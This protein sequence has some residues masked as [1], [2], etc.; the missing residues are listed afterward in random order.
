[1]IFSSQSTHSFIKCSLSLN[2][3]KILIKNSYHL[4]Y[5]IAEFP[6]RKW[7]Q[8]LKMWEVP[9]NVANIRF[10][11]NN[12][13]TLKYVQI[14][15]RLLQKIK[16]FK[17]IAVPE[18]LKPFPENFPFKTEPWNVQKQALNFAYNFDACLHDVDMGLGKSKISIDLMNQF[19]REGLINGVIVFAPLSCLYN[20]KDE[21]ETHS[22]SNC[23]LVHKKIMKPEKI[24]DSELSFFV[25]GVESLSSSDY[26][27][28]ILN[29]LGETLGKLGFVC[30]EVH[31]FKNPSSNRTKKLL[32]LRKFAIK[33]LAMSGTPITNNVTDIYAIF[34]IINPDII[35]LT[36][37]ESFKYRYC[38]F[39]MNNKIIGVKND[40]ELG[41]LISPYVFEARKEDHM[42]DLPEK[43]Y[44][45]KK[46][47]LL[48]KQKEIIL[49]V[50]R[51]ISEIDFEA[52]KQRFQ[53]LSGLM[54]MQQATEGYVNLVDKELTEKYGRETKK[55]Y[56]LDKPM[57]I[58]KIKMLFDL[59]EELEGTSVIVWSKFVPSIEKVWDL[60]V[61]KYSYDEIVLYYGKTNQGTREANR[62]KFMNRE[63]WC[64]LGNPACGGTGLNGL[65]VAHTMI[66]LN[67][68]FNFSDREQSESRI[69]RPKQKNP[70]CNYIDI[71]AKNS[72]DMK[73]LQALKEKMDT[74]TFL[75]SLYA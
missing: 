18:V 41:E 20:W 10:F 46:V 7:L 49:D 63:A 71:V 61:K 74:L 34:K 1:M 65:T 30:D 58:P 47:E 37:F 55:I 57:K 12:I 43:V 42:K 21:I 35:G 62:Q 51:D 8:D 33:T 5:K 36:T 13:Q 53:A 16:N 9:L 73:I 29:K 19:Y 3:K 64:F 11:Q 22:N 60:F 72:P 69:H 26:L 4:R 24:D 15:D 17:E 23:F 44:T 67:S 6:H 25:C 70:Q 28:D 56:W 45:K 75:R 66:Y 2:E 68:S 59:F 27:F 40:K 31:K 50:K 14:E 48:P 39:G 54:H 32:K 52:P 38:I